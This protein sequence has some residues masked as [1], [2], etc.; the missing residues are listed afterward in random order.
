MILNIVELP[1]SAYHAR[2]VP[3][4]RWQVALTLAAIVLTAVI[5]AV[6]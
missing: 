4:R 3:P 5:W 1:R 2:S 6:T